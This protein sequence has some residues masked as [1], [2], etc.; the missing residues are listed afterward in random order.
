[1]NVRFKKR[2]ISLLPRLV[3]ASLILSSITFAAG[4][5]YPPDLQKTRKS[6]TA[7]VKPITD[8]PPT[9]MP[10]RAQSRQTYSSDSK[11]DQAT[12]YPPEPPKEG[13]AINRN[14][15]IKRNLPAPGT[16]VIKGRIPRK[17]GV[18]KGSLIPKPTVGN[19][20]NTSRKSSTLPFSDKSDKKDNK[21]K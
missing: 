18:H 15:S 20:G 4:S 9:P 6:I 10:D 14:L 19:T 2:T 5:E 13:V 1:M 21:P 16:K 17:E 7:N 3:I 8:K 11:R 12:V